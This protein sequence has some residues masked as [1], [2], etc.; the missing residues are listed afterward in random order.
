MD[1][2]RYTRKEYVSGFVIDET[3]LSTINLSEEKNYYFG[4]SKVKYTNGREKLHLRKYRNGEVW[5]D[6]TLDEDEARVLHKAL[7]KYFAKQHDQAHK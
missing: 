2:S 7:T 6:M 1:E 3:F 4:L 5:R